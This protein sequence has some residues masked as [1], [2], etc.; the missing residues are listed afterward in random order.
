MIPL[1]PERTAPNIDAFDPIAR[2]FLSR[3]AYADLLAPSVPFIVERRCADHY[4]ARMVFYGILVARMFYNREDVSYNEI[5]QFAQGVSR[6]RL[7]EYIGFL[8][9][10]ELLDVVG[11]R[12]DAR[13][14]GRNGPNGKR[15]GVDRTTYRTAR[16]RIDTERLVRESAA[17]W[18]E[19]IRAQAA[20]IPTGNPRRRELIEG[21][22]EMEFGEELLPLTLAGGGL[23]ARST[24]VGWERQPF[25]KGHSPAPVVAVTTPVGEQHLPH[26][27]GASAG[28]QRPFPH[29]NS[30]R[31][32]T[33]TATIAP[34][35]G[36]QQPFPHG[37][38][39][40]SPM[41]TDEGGS[42][43]PFPHGNSD[44]SP[45][46]TAI[47]PREPSPFPY[48]DMVGGWVGESVGREGGSGADAPAL[49]LTDVRS[50]IQA[51]VTQTIQS[52]VAQAIQNALASLTFPQLIPPAPAEEEVPAA[53]PDE[54][55]IPVGPVGAWQ[56]LL[57]R[58]AT[59]GERGQIEEIVRA[60]T[61]HSGGAA[62]YWLTRAMYTVAIEGAE[63][64]SLRYVRG[65]L[66]RLSRAG[67]WASEA[68]ILA[69]GEERLTSGAPDP[70]PPHPPRPP[71]GKPRA[72]HVEQGT[73]SA[74]PVVPAPARSPLP[75]D[76]A[77]HPAIAT[78]RRFAGPDAAIT[79]ERARQLAAT[80]TR[81]DVWEV[82][83]TN[84]QARYGSKANF[85]HFDGL[86]ETY[87]RETPVGTAAPGEPP[88]SVAIIH[89][90]PGLTDEQRDRW[91]RRY[92]AA[93]TPAEKRAV[94]ARLEQE[95]PR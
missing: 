13:L 43:P 80:V 83:L 53:P 89:H 72:P 65:V 55:A 95:H 47:S 31:S 84:W 85:V 64:L 90:Y 52:E 2:L 28:E 37:N 41:G 4:Q 78:W 16:Y 76:L 94:I 54:P 69:A 46:G 7:G 88:L 66:K 15:P 3:A 18:S 93:T 50:V 48:G 60:F 77:E 51:E 82:V 27:N 49:S 38:S 74:P 57:G 61:A 6:S 26:G 71:R 1:T 14:A 86:L 91:I 12:E 11:H 73:P 19:L 42:P 75:T 70:E 30:D 33:G 34:T 56:Q 63:K 67:Q 8:C 44:R 10:H 5:A 35:P 58:P 62:A 39:D 17:A 87:R 25:S 59:L 81:L 24:T 22:M 20:G 92:H 29:G 21:Q 40:R 9:E 23:S 45:T 36:E 32:P 68:L 79:L